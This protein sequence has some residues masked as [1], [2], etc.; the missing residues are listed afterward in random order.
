MLTQNAEEIHRHYSH[1][2][3]GTGKNIQRLSYSDSFGTYLD[4]YQ[5]FNHGGSV[6]QFDQDQAIDSPQYG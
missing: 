4:V 2:I 6:Y 1:Y 3:P 5:A